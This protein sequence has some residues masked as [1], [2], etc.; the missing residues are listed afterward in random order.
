MSTSLYQK[1]RPK[2]FANLVGQ[3]HIRTTLLNELKS[4]TVAHAYLFS[5]PR[6]IGKTTTARLLARAVNCKAQ[7][8]G[9]PDNSCESCEMILGGRA[10]DV[11]EIDAASHTGVDHVRENIIENARVAP[12]QLGWKV[13]VIDEV[14]MLST[15]AFNAL[16]KTL[17]EPPAHTMFILATT[18]IHKVPST[19]VSRCERF[20]FRKISFDDMTRRLAGL[21][22]AEGVQV[23]Q[24][25][26]EAIAKRSEGALR[27]AESLLG[28]VLALDDKKITVEVAEIV[29]PH[30]ESG[31]ILGLFEEIV[32]GQTKPAIARVNQLMDDGVMLTEFTKDLIEFT[33]KVLLYVVQESL[34]P[35]QYLDL[36]K[37][38]VA[39]IG[40]LVKAIPA[41]EISRIIETLIE[42]LE[43]QKST[44][45]PQL[46]LE[47]AIVKLAEKEVAGV[48]ESGP[49]DVE[50]P[51]PGGSGG[52]GEAGGDKQ[53]EAKAGEKTEAAEKPAAGVNPAAEAKPV[54]EEKPTVA[55]SS[56]EESSA[57]KSAEESSAEKSVWSKKEVGDFKVGEESA[58]EMP[59]EGEAVAPGAQ[60]ISLDAV[61]KQWPELLDEM[62]RQ[63]HA[64]HLT[65]KVGQVVDLK[66]DKLMVGYE[67]Q[68]YQDRINDA[69]NRS[70]IDKVFK[71]VFGR[72]L[73]VEALV[74]AE[75]GGKADNSESNIEQPTEE[76]VA[77]V[78][79]L[80]A[81][82]F[83]AGD[84]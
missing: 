51:Q 59:K 79:D 25:V 29:L 52:S 39:R 2:T 3:D 50:P 30:S 26:L 68:F 49:D 10:L 75:Y 57:E 63:N 73:M 72:Q 23:D 48:G 1:Y 54:A 65:F 81:S 74:G 22:K 24:D 15:S 80:A 8:D 53:P 58:K 43:Q 45:I 55:E 36:N 40:N 67:Y 21:A 19:I 70:V 69:R 34:D 6:G 71:N 62:K 84:K 35:L 61:Q 77:N 42:A 13:F 66:G 78:W 37:E 56:T 11:V 17:E 28:Q 46:P 20:N 5:G 12:S 14:H 7:Q 47:L 4:G 76:E 16:L 32:R 31:E 41:A 60:N 33:R 9:E 44:T 27:D 82:S 83:G 64:L 18:E 38:D